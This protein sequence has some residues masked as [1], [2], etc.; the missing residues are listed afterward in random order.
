MTCDETTRAAFPMLAAGV[1]LAT[2][3]IATPLRASEIPFLHVVVDQ[4]PPARPYYKMVGDINGDEALDIVIGGANGPLVWYANPNWEKSAIAESGWRGVKGQIADIDN[5]GDA[6]VVMGGVVWFKNPRIGGGA[7][8]QVR[9]DRQKAHDIE[10][11]DLDLDGRLDVVARD[12]SAF[13]GSGNVLYLYQQANPT[14]WTKRTIQCPHGEGLK[15][16]DLDHDGDSDIV[17]GARWFENPGAPAEQWIEHRYTRRW[18]EP[19]AKVETADFN[20]DN[21]TDIVLTPAEL[22]GETYKVA[23][24][25][26]PPDPREE[27]WPEHIIVPKIEAV[28]H[29]LG[30]GDFDGDGDM[31]VAIAEMHQGSDP[32]EVSVHFSG[33]HGKV[34]RK[35][36]LSTKGS[37]DIVVADIDSDGDPDILGANHAGDRHPLELWINQR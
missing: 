15:L 37:H 14:S 21:R 31:D 8:R 34:W 7:W 17:I 2:C 19:D 32:D 20:K 33:D 10:L 16:A 5:D 4:T 25:E 11:A 6:D 3:V 1:L 26:A 30:V 24:Y 12:Q 22:R 27:D 13:G 23:W 18:T 29:S 35:Q 9:I 36:V 28:I